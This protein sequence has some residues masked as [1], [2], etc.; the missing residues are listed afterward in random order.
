LLSLG[1]S[2]TRRVGYSAGPSPITASQLV[3]VPRAPVDSGFCLDFSLRRAGHESLAR[4]ASLSP[5]SSAWDLV[6]T[7][8]FSLLRLG[9]TCAG[10]A[11]LLLVLFSRRGSDHRL[12]MMSMMITPPAL[13]KSLG[14]RRNHA[15]DFISWESKF[16]HVSVPSGKLFGVARKPG[17]PRSTKL[18]RAPFFPR[19]GFE[20]LWNFHPTPV[21]DGVTR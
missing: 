2:H 20:I 15:V 6:L 4:L 19:C 3:R 16:G 10:V 13:P 8:V 5:S 21:V 17:I 1:S 18:V 7:V 14:F 12:L 9:A 11:V